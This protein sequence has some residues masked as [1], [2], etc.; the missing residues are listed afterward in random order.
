MRDSPKD[1][2]RGGAEE[3]TIQLSDVEGGEV[4]GVHS[5]VQPEHGF[6]EP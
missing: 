4:V 3:A 5:V 1:N 6:A 2:G